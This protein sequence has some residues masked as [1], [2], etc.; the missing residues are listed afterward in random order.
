VD[1]NP[2]NRIDS[3]HHF[4]EYSAEQYPWISEPMG[5]LRRDFLP[6]DLL[7]EANANQVGGVISVQARQ[8]EEETSW[9]LSMASSH[10]WIR[11]VV[12]WLPLQSPDIRETMVPYRDAAKLCGLRHV[13]QDEQ[14]DGFLDR[15]E[16]NNGV[17]SMLEFGWTYDLLIYSRQLPFAIP[18]VDR[19][20]D[21]VFVLDH[22][23]KPTIRSGHHADQWDRDL[24]EL[25]KRSNVFCKF[26]G[27]VTE[28]RDQEWT[29]SQIEP[30]WNTALEA[31]GPSR[32]M[33]GTDWPVC[34]LKASYTRWVNAVDAFASKL[35]A[36]EQ[37]QFWFENAVRAYNLSY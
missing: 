18:F 33:F 10:D 30:Y 35:S 2:S 31:F 24:R 26:S 12:G 22:I 34:L 3:H 28:V 11:G 32:L 15:P 23:A 7:A 20:P 17:R 6:P 19:H 25:A 4:W 9:L 27:V 13:V 16:F 1:S 36:S 37:N 29:S 8:I 21:Q 5:L 14:D